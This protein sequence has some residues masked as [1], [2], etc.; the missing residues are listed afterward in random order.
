MIKEK[1]A[2]FTWKVLGSETVF[3]GKKCYKKFYPKSL[4]PCPLVKAIQYEEYQNSRCSG[5]LFLF[6]W[7]QRCWWLLCSEATK[8][9]I[10]GDGDLSQDHLESMPWD[11]G[12]LMMPLNTHLSWHF[13]PDVKMCE[14]CRALL[15]IKVK[16]YFLFKFSSS[17]TRQF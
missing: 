1:K 3:K 13:C 12:Q 7:T 14:N 9:G 10:G 2:K 11:H 4:L 6:R 17:L 16:T 8:K 15:V 5:C